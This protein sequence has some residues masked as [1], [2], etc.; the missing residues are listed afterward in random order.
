MKKVTRK[1]GS[2]RRRTD[3][4]EPIKQEDD[5]VVPSSSTFEVPVSRLSRSSKVKAEPEAEDALAPTEEFTPEE[6]QALIQEGAAR[7]EVDVLRPRRRKQKSSSSVPK[8][9]PWVVLTTI[10]AGYAG[11]YRKEKIEL[12]YCG[13]G[14]QITA[15]EEYQV[16]EW[17][18]VLEPQCEPCPPHAVCYGEMIM[19]CDPDF[20]LKSHPLS[21]G[22]LV[23][24]P[25]TCEPDGEKVRKVQAVADKAVEVLRERR[26]KWEC[27]ELTEENG[28][29]A[30]AVEIE[31]PALKAEVSQKRRR[32]MTDAEFEDL[33]RGA[34]GEIIA[35]DEVTSDYSG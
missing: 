12:G 2:R 1:S 4:H 24:L 34:M 28:K 20:V 15:M 14:K 8:F 32:G 6:Q 5:M 21:F 31:E 26:A 17:A 33:W 7:G 23:P 29:P 30:T 16:P 9:A 35:R 10:L 19:K 13:V 27:G 11:W 22:G 3:D 25:P 18:R